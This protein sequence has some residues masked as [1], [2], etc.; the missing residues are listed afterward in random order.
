M[1][2]KTQSFG[3]TYPDIV[4]D[5]N[6]VRQAFVN[7]YSWA[8]R[9]ASHPDVTSPPAD[10]QPFDLTKAPVFQYTSAPAF[11]GILPSPQAFMQAAAETVKAPVTFAK[12]VASSAAAAKAVSNGEPSHRHSQ[13]SG[14]QQQIAADHALSDMK[15]AHKAVGPTESVD[16]S[17]VSREWYVDDVVERY[18]NSNFV[19]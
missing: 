16:E 8:Q 18:V 9:T 11:S 19:S 2:R 5:P 17:K 4:G 7:H 13:A 3:Y 6:K 12:Q 10:M 15:D 14:S 1:T